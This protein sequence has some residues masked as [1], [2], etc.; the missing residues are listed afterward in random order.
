MPDY[1]FVQGDDGRRLIIPSTILFDEKD[2]WTKMV[3]QALKRSVQQQPD[4]TDFNWMIRWLTTKDFVRPRTPVVRVKVLMH[5]NSAI[6][7]ENG[8]VN[9]QSAPGGVFLV[10]EEESKD[11]KPS[12]QIRIVWTDPAKGDMSGILANF[13]TPKGLEFK[14]EMSFSAARH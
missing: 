3:D 11:G 7:L 10:P 9:G 8:E 4:L 5:Q 12:E 6:T 1:I 13:K 14:R 2:G